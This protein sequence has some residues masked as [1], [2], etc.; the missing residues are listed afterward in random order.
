MGN[1]VRGVEDFASRPN[2]RVGMALLLGSDQGTALGSMGLGGATAI[3]P[4]MHMPRPT[5]PGEFC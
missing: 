2:V 5:S 1:G 3:G 4:G